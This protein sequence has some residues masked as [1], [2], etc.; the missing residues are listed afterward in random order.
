MTT[1]SQQY[2]LRWNNHRTNLLTVFGQLYKNSAFTDVTIAIDCGQTIKCHKIVLAACSSYFQTLFMDL[3]DRNGIHPIVVLKDVQFSEIKAILEYMYHGEVNV[4]QD[5][6]TGLLKIAEMLKVKGLVEENAG[7]RGEDHSAHDYRREDTPMET[8]RERSPPPTISTSGGNVHSSSHVPSPPHSSTGSY[9]MYNSTVENHLTSSMWSSMPQTLPQSLALSLSGH[10]PST[11]STSSILGGSYDSYETSPHKRKKKMMQPGLLVHDKESIQGSILRKVLNVSHA[12]SSQSMPLLQSDSHESIYYH[13]GCSNSERPTNGNRRTSIDPIAQ[14]EI[15]HSPGSDEDEKQLSPQSVG[16][17]N[18]GIA[19]QSLNQSKPEWKRYK[20]YTR[21]DIM[22]AISAVQ[23]GMSAVQAARKYNVPSRTLYDKVKKLGIQ[24]SRPPKR[25]LGSNGANATWYGVAGNANGGVYN[26]AQP[27]DANV[28]VNVAESSVSKGAATT[29]SLEICIYYLLCIAAVD[30]TFTS[31][32]EITTT[33]NRDC[34]PECICLSPKQVLCNTGGLEDIPTQ[35][36]SESVEELSLT[37][38]NFPLIKGD[39]FSGLKVLRKLTLDG[40][41]ITSIRP[42]AFRGLHRLRELSIQHTPLP[43]IEQFSFATLQNISVL[44]LAN[45]KIRYV[46]GYSF[47][48]TSNVNVILLSNNPLLTIRSH[49]FAGLTY[50]NSLIFPSGIRTIEQGAFDGLQH[51]GQLKLS[52]MDLSGLQAY[53]FRGL[54]NVRSLYIQESDLGIVQRNAFAGLTHVDR[55]NVLNN[56]VDL[57]ERL[58]L[59]HENY[60]E[61]LRFHGNH[62]LEAPRHARDVVLEVD[63]ISAID[64]HFPC[65]CQAHNVLESDFARGDSVE[66]QRRNYCIS[67]FEYNGKPMNVVDFDLVARCHD[68][69]IQDNLGSGVVEVSR[70]SALLLIAFLLSTNFFR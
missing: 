14:G 41:N 28:N 23:N 46:E 38:N 47:A 11:H 8:L 35:Q 55:L 54:S 65:D 37:K 44:L 58:Y 27:K 21:D 19:N 29:G 24:T 67:P 70:L 3:P 31:D 33:E 66:F 53:T 30:L 18:S 62:V 1:S 48:G 7:S 9:G 20:Q 45:N 25:M 42:F 63:T 51:V 39:A 69:V 32:A 4:A 43:C 17:T 52:Y 59:R 26:S 60:I 10:Q 16:K 15:I 36:L 56:K 5:E 68:N 50:V 61:M 64:N 57:I 34:P 22:S 6:L 2:C 12:D 40:N 13:S 49:A